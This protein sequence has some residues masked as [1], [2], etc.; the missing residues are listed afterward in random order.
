VVVALHEQLAA[1]PSL[2]LLATLD[3]AVA[4]PDRP[5]MPG[6][7]DEWPNWRLPLPVRLEQLEEHP[8]ARRVAEVLER[9]VHPEE[10]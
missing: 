6:T 2:V 1:T 10:A 5:N 3:D 4:N 9:A 8:V 7:T